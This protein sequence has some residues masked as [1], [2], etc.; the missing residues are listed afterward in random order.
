MF[1]PE[2]AVDLP[3][4]ELKK[5]LRVLSGPAREAWVFE[6]V[7]QGNVPDFLRVPTLIS[8]TW[9]G[10]KKAYLE[11]C[12]DYLCLGTDNDFVYTPVNIETAQ[13]I[14]DLIEAMLPTRKLV[15]DIWAQAA[16]QLAPQPWGPPYDASMMSSERF[17]AQNEKIQKAWPG[18]AR[19][20]LTAGHFKD[21]VLV[22]ELETRRDR[23]CIYGWHQKNGVPI[24]GV[25]I[26][27]HER[28]YVDY[29][30]CPRFVS[31]TLTVEEEVFL[32]ADVMQDSGKFRSVS[33]VPSSVSRVPGL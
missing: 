31:R 4:R 19:G 7:R 8:L 20:V 29:S 16:V 24:Q 10:G 22:P 32:V 2:R 26:N 33:S 25:Q 18:E 12:P 27:A 13:H 9:V 6:N 14:C 28:T 17:I 23:T 1:F 3:G 5:A 21:Y 30:Q 11:V 15:D